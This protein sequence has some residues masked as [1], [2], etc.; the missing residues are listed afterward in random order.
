M[1]SAGLSLL[2]LRYLTGHA[3]RD[4]LNEYTSIE[5]VRAMRHYFD[6][7]RPLLEAIATQARR[8]AL[9]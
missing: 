3:T 5:A 1:H 4:I 7:V 6:T 9:V 8:L 2:E